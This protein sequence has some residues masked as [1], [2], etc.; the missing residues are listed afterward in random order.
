MNGDKAQLT[1]LIS[2]PFFNNYNDDLEFG[3]LT[4]PKNTGGIA[5]FGGD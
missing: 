2:R 5:V 1:Q 3:G 4:S